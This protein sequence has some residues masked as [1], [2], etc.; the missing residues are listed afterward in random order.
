MVVVPATH[1]VDLDQL[2]LIAGAAFVALADEHEFAERFPGCQPG[3]MPPFG[4]LYGIPTYCAA[5]L[6]D[7]A[8]IVFNAGTHTEAVK[9]SFANFERLAKPIVDRVS[10]QREAIIS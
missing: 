3:A 5:E 1:W 10:R 2:Q 7:D 6:R 4:N 8:E 9:T